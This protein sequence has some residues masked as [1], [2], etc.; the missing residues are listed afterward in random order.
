VTQPYPNVLYSTETMAF[1]MA[2]AAL[3]RAGGTPVDEAIEA[4]IAGYWEFARVRPSG[5]MLIDDMR[6]FMRSVAGQSPA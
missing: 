6:R 3:R 5:S 4:G 1:I 2:V